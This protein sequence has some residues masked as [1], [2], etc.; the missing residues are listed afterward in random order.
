MLLYLSGHTYEAFFP[1]KLHEE[2]IKCSGKNLQRSSDQGL[3]F[4]H[5]TGILRVDAY[6]NTVFAGMNGYVEHSDPYY[7]KSCMSYVITIASCPI[8]MQPKKLLTKTALLT[9]KAEVVVL[10]H[11]TR[12]LIPIINM[13]E[14]LAPAIGLPSDR[15][16][17][18]I[19]IYGNNAGA[20][21]LVDMIIPQFLTR[22]K[23]YHINAI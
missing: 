19:S 18:H 5:S 3:I 7:M 20:L 17:M 4:D 13:V 21:I 1:Q 11:Y 16:S 14:S 6:P 10:A 22:S 9:V 23:H 12:E 8:L 15:T 2:A